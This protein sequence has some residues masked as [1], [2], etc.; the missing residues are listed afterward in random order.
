LVPIILV[1]LL[2]PLALEAQELSMFSEVVWDARAAALGHNG[3]LAA[4]GPGALFTNPALLANLSEPM[5]SASGRIKMGSIEDDDEYYKSYDNK[6]TMHPKI[7]QVA[8]AFPIKLQSESATMVGG[9]GYQTCF[10]Q[11][12]KQKVDWETVNGDKGSREVTSKG[13]YA[14]LTPGAAI[15]F[16]DKYNLGLAINIKSPVLGSGSAE[17]EYKYPGHPDDNHSWKVDDEFTGSYILFGGTAEITTDFTVGLAYRGALT[18]KIKEEYKEPGQQTD[19]YDISFKM[20]S[21]MGLAGSY[22]FGQA[23]TAFGEYQTRPFS[24]LEIEID[25]DEEDVQI[26]NGSAVKLG[27]EFGAG[28]PIRLGYYREAIPATDYSEDDGDETPKA[29]N[30]FTGGIGFKMGTANMDLYFDYGSWSF[31]DEYNGETTETKETIY[32]FGVTFGV[33]F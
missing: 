27:V 5:G 14:T 21:F 12:F 10:D 13:G 32:K 22:R 8:G 28:T 19:K 26:D 2:A 30:G 29:I 20:P 4:A 7:T 6:F 23:I 9:V 11:G 15:R 3:I 1:L 16:N 18:L 25:G 17:G 31:E 24:D 33:P